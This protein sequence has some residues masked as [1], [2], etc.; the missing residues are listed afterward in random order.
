MRTQEERRMLLHQR[1]DQLR[2]RRVKKAVT[3]FSTMSALLLVVLTS[4]IA[5]WNS[6]TVPE[7][8]YT[9]SSLLGDSAGGYVLA[10]VLAF[11]AGVVLTVVLI[12]RRRP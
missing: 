3:V 11:V 4:M 5:S 10:A 12:R 9:G 2:R 7:G 6:L 1:A 8:Q